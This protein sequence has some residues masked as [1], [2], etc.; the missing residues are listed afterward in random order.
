MTENKNQRTYETQPALNSR[1][2]LEPA[3][4]TPAL[5]KVSPK[6]Y[7]RLTPKQREELVFKLIDF[8]KRF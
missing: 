8:L 2:H 7:A 4:G 6:Q 1:V 3:A 5:E